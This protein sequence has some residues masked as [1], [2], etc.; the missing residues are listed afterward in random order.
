[1]EEGAKIHGG[2]EMKH[3]ALRLKSGKYQK[4]QAVLE[5]AG[6][7]VSDRKGDPHCIYFSDPDGHRLQLLTPAERRQAFIYARCC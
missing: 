1:M 2:S 5:G 7:K 3:M 4:V 6:I